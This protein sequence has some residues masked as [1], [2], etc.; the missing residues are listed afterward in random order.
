MA[1]IP[2]DFEMQ[3]EGDEEVKSKFGSV[4]KAAEDLG[5]KTDTA[6]S[7]AS[8]ARTN[9]LD[10]ARGIADVSASAFQLWQNFDD[11]EKVE[12]RIAEAEKRVDTARAGLLGAQEKLTKLVVSGTT[13]GTEYEKAALRMSAAEKELSLAQERVQETQEDLSEAH[14]SFALSVA[15]ASLSAVSGLTSVVQMFGKSQVLAN[16]ATALSGK[17]H[18]GAGAGALAQAA[19]TF[20]ATIATKGLTLA[21]KLFHLAMGPVGLIILG[22]STAIGLFATNAFG[23]RDSVNKMGEAIGNAIPI[24]KPLLDTLAGIAETIFPQEEATKSLGDTTA[25]TLADMG[26]EYAKLHEEET[27]WLQSSTAGQQDLMAQFKQLESDFSASSL[28]MVNIGAESADKQAASFQMLESAAKGASATMAVSL[29]EMG[30]RAERMADKV[31][32]AVNKASAAL[33]SLS[34]AGPSSGKSVANISVKKAADGFSGIVAEP[35]MFLA[36]ERGPEAVNISPVQG[37][38]RG[39]FIITVVT[40][41]DG[42]EVA[43][44]VSKVQGKS[45]P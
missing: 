43:R 35:T 31:A 39:N 34:L 19:G 24:L 18:A 6:G 4:G 32:K 36:G 37:G 7:A 23:L 38:V 33:R 11:L 10:A 3:V 44:S 41:L 16:F 21:T 15:P 20:K 26:L 27:A 22:V 45:L 5:K 29:D 42:R 25:G 40:N 28:G 1:G 17:I 12:T 13:S 8:K 9:Y 2:I 30:L 14:T